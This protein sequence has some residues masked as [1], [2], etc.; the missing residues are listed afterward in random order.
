MERLRQGTHYSTEEGFRDRTSRNSIATAAA[1]SQG[2]RSRPAAPRRGATAAGIVPR[3]PELIAT[4][5]SR[6]ASPVGDSAW[7]LG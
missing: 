5:P 6:H 1:R 2:G 3:G 4:Q 7:E